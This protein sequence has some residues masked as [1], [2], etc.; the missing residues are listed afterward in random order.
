MP[1][2][3]T[4]VARH[5]PLPLPAPALGA[6]LIRLPSQNS[7]RVAAPPALALPPDGTLTAALLSAH[8]HATAALR[9]RAGLV[10]TRLELL[11]RWSDAQVMQLLSGSLSISPSLSLFLLPWGGGGRPE[12]VA[13]WKGEVG[14]MCGCWVDLGQA[15]TILGRAA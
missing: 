3:A 11:L 4:A 14:G 9:C 12:A 5:A 13:Q 15:R 6:P 7:P 1:N 2:Q 10:C 8:A